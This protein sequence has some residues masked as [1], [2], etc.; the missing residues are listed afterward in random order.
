MWQVGTLASFSRWLCA[1][2]MYMGHQSLTH[3]EWLHSKG[4]SRVDE[5][6][7][8]LG[9]LEQ[10]T[11]RFGLVHGHRHLAHLARL[12]HELCVLQGHQRNANCLRTPQRS[13]CS[14]QSLDWEGCSMHCS[15]RVAKVMV[16]LIP[17]NLLIHWVGAWVGAW[18][19]PLGQSMHVLAPCHGT[20]SQSTD[21]CGDS[22]QSAC[23][24]SWAPPWRMHA[25]HRP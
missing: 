16:L 22:Q 13:H 18:V 9:E 2:N 17:S 20:M 25:C 23:T 11:V 15:L 7:G 24:R 12:L 5:M 3:L 6:D 14:H 8:H 21:A 1:S 4:R 19:G 10:L